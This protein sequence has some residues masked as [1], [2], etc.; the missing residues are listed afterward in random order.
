VTWR[1][2]IREEGEEEAILAEEVVEEVPVEALEGQEASEEGSS[3]CLLDGKNA[4]HMAIP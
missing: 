3:S 4:P 2:R 1:W